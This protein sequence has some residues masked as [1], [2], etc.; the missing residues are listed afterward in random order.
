MPSQLLVVNLRPWLK[1]CCDYRDFLQDSSITL[2]TLTTTSRL[3]YKPDVFNFKL[4]CETLSEIIDY[5]AIKD[6]FEG[7]C[8][9]RAYDIRN[10][11]IR[12]DCKVR[13]M[14]SGG[15]DSTLVLVA[16][17]RTWDKSELERVEV[18]LS[19]S[20]IDEYREFFFRFIQPNFRLINTVVTHYDEYFKDSIVITGEHGDQLFGS[21]IIHKI[22]ATNGD[23]EDIKKNPN[24]YDILYKTFSSRLREDRAA[25]FL[26]H[27]MPI[28]YESPIRINNVL[29][30]IW[31]W[32]FS[33]KWQN[34]KFRELTNSSPQNLKYNSKRIFHFFD[35]CYF[36]KWAIENQES[37]IKF[38]GG[39]E[40]Y[41]MPAKKIICDFVG[42]ENYL[43]KKKYGSQAAISYFRESKKREFAITKF[44]NFTQSPNKYLKEG[45]RYG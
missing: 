22:I 44:M 3:N 27:Y 41:K 17:L 12:R 26:N 35:T 18:V 1:T 38:P 9:L 5:P 29:D 15:I 32:N 42:N 36:Q 20:S 19:S 45:F 23:L 43:N 30:F 6:D 21:D 28:T 10:I 11:A 25:K 7:Y 13:V 24:Y 4:A 8:D 37:G 34:V 33:Q 40:T 14:W 2:G 31:F 16:M 39:L